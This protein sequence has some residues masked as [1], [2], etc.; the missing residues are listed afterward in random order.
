MTRQ[1]KSEIKTFAEQQETLNKPINPSGEGEDPAIQALL[2]DDFT[3]ISDIDA[4]AVA[5]MVAKIVRGELK[6]ELDGT[7]EK[8]TAKILE[9]EETAKRADKDRI[10]FAE[11]MY[12]LA[13]RT[14]TTTPDK[15]QASADGAKLIEQAR[16]EAAAEAAARRLEID[17]ILAESPTITMVHPGVPRTY[18][19]G[20]SKIT[21][22]IP[23]KIP[24]EHRVF[25]LEPNVPTEIPLPIYEH[26]IKEMEEAQK[27]NKLNEVLVGAKNDFGKAIQADQVVDP[28]YSERIKESL[29]NKGIVFPSGG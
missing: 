18:R 9:M 3:K 10:K 15:L 14:R 13:E 12:A 21:K 29:N 5:K 2:S 16:V 24:F 17:K 28:D 7:M 19:V 1:K 25:T 8:L 26:Y 22:M 20:D 23:F 11:E 4:L 27:R 6:E